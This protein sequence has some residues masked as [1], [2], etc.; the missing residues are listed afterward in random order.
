MNKRPLAALATLAAATVRMAR[1][2]GAEP[3]R[4]HQRRRRATGR[5]D[6][7]RV[8]PRCLERL[9]GVTAHPSDVRQGRSTPAVS[10][11]RLGRPHGC[12]RGRRPV[13]DG[14]PNSHGLPDRAAGTL[15]AKPDTSHHPSNW[16]GGGP[17]RSEPNVGVAVRRSRLASCVR[18][19]RGDG[20]SRLQRRWRRKLHVQLRWHG[21]H[22]LG[23]RRTR[24]R[25]RLGSPLL[26]RM[27]GMT[28]GAERRLPCCGTRR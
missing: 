20:W 17:V 14:R 24:E 13:A 23:L 8:G 12:A 19:W 7:E 21:S 1:P 9:L 28:G 26:W 15:L 10:V 6:G 4:D 5:H 27:A 3:R 18:S 25:H 22:A 11:G 2:A 16:R